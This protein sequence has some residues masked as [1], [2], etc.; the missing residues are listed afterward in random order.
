MGFSLVT[1]GL[2]R[3]HL[4]NGVVWAPLI[5]NLGY[6]IGFLIVILGRQ[7][8]FT[9]NTVTPIIAL[10]ARRDLPTLLR[11]VR[12]WIIVLLANLIGAAIFA[13][14]VA[15]TN[16]FSEEA[17]RSFAELGNEAARPGGVTIFLRA[18]FAGWLIALMVWMLP[19]TRA[20]EVLIILVM[21]YIVG[22]AAL[23]HVIAGSVEVLYAVANGDISFL[24]YLRYLG[25]TLAGNIV[26]GVLLVAVLNHAQVISGMDSRR[27]K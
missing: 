11:T 12:L 8:L 10:L 9:E 24:H 4:P 19:G 7:Q 21:T 5:G 18:I 22:L 23:S 2:L 3:S 25:P 26:G 16:I 6:T 20:S 17:R 13:W 15:N 1:Q 27:S 14:V